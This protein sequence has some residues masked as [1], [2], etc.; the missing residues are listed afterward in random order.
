[1]L[2]TGY[3]VCLEDGCL[4]NLDVEIEF[5]R[6]RISQ[7]CSAVGKKSVQARALKNKTKQSVNNFSEANFECGK[8]QKEI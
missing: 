6:I 1:M 8:E 2:S 7:V 4:W 5:E 3:V